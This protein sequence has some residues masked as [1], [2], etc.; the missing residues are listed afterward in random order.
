[1][2]PKYYE[3]PSTLHVGTMPLRADYCPQGACRLSLN[4]TWDFRYFTRAED[5]PE[6]IAAQRWQSAATIPVP[7]VWQA[8]GY[9]AYFYSDERYPFPYDPPYMPRENPCGVYQREF[10]LPQGDA[11]C[12]L[13]FDGVDSCFFVW[14]NGYLAGYSQVSHSN[15]EFD[16]TAL[17]TPGV[18]VLT[19]AVLKWCDGTYLEDQDKIRASGIFRDVYLL[20]RPREHVWDVQLRGD[21]SG[22]IHCRWD[23]VGTPQEVELELDDP[24][25]KPLLRQRVQDTQAILRVDAPLLWTAETPYLYTLR[26]RAA[27]ETIAQRVGLRTIEIR[28]GLVLLNGQRVFMHG[29]NRHDSDPQTGYAVSREHILRDMRLMKEHNIN[30]IRT[31]HYPNAPCFYELADEYGFYV[32][33]EADL[34]SHGTRALYGEKGSMSLLM[35][36][37]D[38]RE[39]VLD[40]VQ[41]GV[42]PHANHACVLLWSMGNESGYGENIEEALRWTRAYDPTR[43][44][45]YESYVFCPEDYTPEDGLMDVYSRMYPPIEQID[46]YFDREHADAETLALALRPGKSDSRKPYVLCEYCHAMGNGPGDLEDYERCFHRHPEIFGAFVWEWCDHAVYAGRTSAGEPKYLYGG[47]F[48]EVFSDGNFCM[49]GLVLPDRR[50]STS[51]EELGNVLRPIRACGMAPDGQG[52]LLQSQLD[53]TDAGERYQ[54]RWELARDGVTVAQGE[55]ALPP[56]PPRETVTVALPLPE[57]DGGNLSLRLCYVQRNAGCLTQAGRIAGFDQLILSSQP[58]KLPPLQGGVCQVRESQ[59]S[60]LVEGENFRYRF[61]KATG[62]F[63]SMVYGEEEMLARPMDYHVWRAP[64]DNDRRIRVK[65]QE[66]GYDRCLTRTYTCQC[67]QQEG[68]VSIACTLSLTP[69]YL[70]RT[71]TVDAL[72]R[73]GCDGTV[74]VRMDVSRGAELPYLPRFGLRMFLPECFTQATYLGY[75]PGESYVDRRQSCWKARFSCPVDHLAG[76]YLKP[77]ESG[78][79]YGC[80]WAALSREDGLTMLAQSET[81]FSFNASPYTEEQLTATTHA[82]ALVPCGCTVF[83]VDYKQSGIGSNS[84][85]PALQEKYQLKETSFRFAFRLRFTHT[86]EA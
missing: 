85:G 43:L 14:V 68:V 20:R 61:D 57:C 86:L 21:A 84:C 40:R 5:V 13:N 79:R 11:K 16:I 44:T 22:E 34:E 75:G 53:F 33:G 52:V 46:A 4:G 71:A 30:A 59:D 76:P 36:D 32:I 1:M 18:N 62:A 6:D 81:P 69:C 38:Y 67:T 48:G 26:L 37:P 24:E 51:L 28:D 63:S 50:I 35:R 15:S 66:A 70:Q 60:I 31:S 25:G 65:W 47:D 17:V 29:V 10:S 7:S 27:G 12:Y 3:D 55:T 77:Q 72:W 49:D 41:R 56:M 74:D 78:S 54:L 83:C 19:V 42:I 8:H 39:A 58:R 64:T 73:I 80:D 45:H 2:L 82:D 9:D 23:W